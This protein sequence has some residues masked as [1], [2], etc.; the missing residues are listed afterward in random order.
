MSIPFDTPFIVQHVP[1]LTAPT[2]EQFE[3]IVDAYQSPEVSLAPVAP[4]TLGIQ[5]HAQ[6]Q[7]FDMS[8][9]DTADFFE[10]KRTTSML[11]VLVFPAFAME[12]AR[13]QTDR[14]VSLKKR[15]DHVLPDS[16]L[17]MAHGPVW[18]FG[19]EEFVKIMLAPTCCMCVADAIFHQDLN[20]ALRSWRPK[21]YVFRTV[22]VA[23]ECDDDWPWEFDTLD[24]YDELAMQ[25][26][27]EK[28][29][30]KAKKNRRRKPNRDHS[31]AAR[32]LDVGVRQDPCSDET[33]DV[34]N[35]LL[36]IPSFTDNCVDVAR[37]A[38]LNVR[39]FD[40]PFEYSS[41][42][43]FLRA[44]HE[45]MLESLSGAFAKAT[46]NLDIRRV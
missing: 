30:G 27:A 29:D 19:A 36:I 16:N 6:C 44:W 15:D 18:V 1:V 13:W 34:A 39:D 46:E 37:A 31:R 40:L 24:V 41:E 14:L 42:A 38:P 4:A 22:R 8:R 12:P 28:V 5:R 43:I 7:Y 32:D 20:A 11:L 23:P 45:T 21:Q 2:L 35:K 26:F 9:E 17:P 25:F 10:D 3:G 33:L